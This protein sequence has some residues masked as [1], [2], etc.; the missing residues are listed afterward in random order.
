MSRRVPRGL[1]VAME[2]RA[3]LEVA[4]LLLALP[5]LRH[6]PRGDGHPVLLLPGFGAGEGSLEPLRLFLQSRGYHV[7]TWGLGR[8]RGFSRRV[9]NAIEKKVRY[10][11]HHHRRKV[12]LIGWSLGGVFAFYAAH[13]APEC[14]RT[15]IAMGSPLR[16][17]PD[18]PP[19]PAV[20]ALYTALAHPMSPIAHQARSRSRAMRLAPP[21]PSTCIYSRHDGIVRPDQ[22]TMDGDPASHENV[23]VPGSHLGMGVNSLAMWVIA[24]RLAERENHWRPFVPSGPIAPIFRALRLTPQAA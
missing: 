11:H 15:V 4:T 9:T 8:N 23:R 13:V 14:I 3:A 24:D 12:S 20:V 16:L 10:L 21:V 2:A 17:D 18:R 5:L 22:A 1:L 19:P 7:E 6:A